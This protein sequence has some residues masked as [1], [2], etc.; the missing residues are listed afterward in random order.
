MGSSIVRNLGITY[1]SKTRLKFWIEKISKS[2]PEN[3]LRRVSNWFFQYPWS[4][5]SVRIHW[6]D[7]DLIS[8]LCSRNRLHNVKRH[9]SHACEPSLSISYAWLIN[10]YILHLQCKHHASERSGYSSIPLSFPQA[11][12]RFDHQS[13]QAGVFPW[14]DATGYAPRRR[15]ALRRLAGAPGNRNSSDTAWLT[16]PPLS[17]SS[18]VFSRRFFS[19]LHFTCSTRFD[20]RVHWN[21]IL[22]I[23]YQPSFFQGNIR[24]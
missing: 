20:R 11:E 1:I 21:L 19:S 12:A 7:G 18:V 16:L 9:L 2:A 5:G 3:F 17:P 6:T 4:H 23:D 8:E 15:L 13:D 14:P 22:L 10:G 24:F